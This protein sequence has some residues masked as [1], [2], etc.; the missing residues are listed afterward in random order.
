MT[1]NLPNKKGA[2]YTVSELVT[3]GDVSI[4]FYIRTGGG[5]GADGFAMSVFDAE[6]LTELESLIAAAHTG[7]GLGYGVAGDDGS[8]VGDAF[9]VEIDTWH[10]VY[11]GPTELHTDPTPENHSA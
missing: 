5:T 8:W 2:I 10:H 1:G 6:D 11:N 3:P 9:H 7:G 4:S